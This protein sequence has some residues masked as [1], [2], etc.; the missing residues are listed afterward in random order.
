MTKPPTT[1]S[2]SIFDGTRHKISL[3]TALA[4][5]ISL[6]IADPIAAG[7]HY[8]DEPVFG[9]SFYYEAYGEQHGISVVLCHGTGDLGGRIW[10]NSVADLSERFHVYVPD[11]PGFGR[12]EKRNELYSPENYANFLNWFIKNYTQPPVYLVGHSMGGAISLYFAGIYPKTIEKLVLVDAAGI[13]HRA[14]F[15]KNVLDELITGEFKVGSM[16][17]LKE[18]LRSLKHMVNSTIESID[19]NLMPD[20][21]S[22]ALR[23]PVFRK[24]VLRGDP[25]RISGMAL[26]Q[27]D[28]SG[29]MER[30]TVPTH[31]IWG[32]LDP[33]APLRTGIMLAVDISKTYLIV[34]K[35]LGHSPMLE[36]PERFNSSL[37]KALASDTVKSFA[38]A[39]NRPFS[40]AERSDRTVL[41]GRGTH[42]EGDFNILLI[43]DSLNITLENLTAKKIIIENSEVKLDNCVIRSKTEG[44]SVINSTATL[45]GVFVSGSTAILSD[46]SKLDIAGSYLQGREESVLARTATTVLF[47]VSRVKSLFQNSYKHGVVKL[48][49]GEQI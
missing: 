44:I 40:S 24:T 46:N 45:T 15:T 12:S 41:G 10:E 49:P 27:T 39:G 6:F 22:E 26:I 8:A 32:E 48:G 16:N 36:D 11:L 20:D 3:L 17:V 19:S 13:L 31:L 33:I 38:K 30:V 1:L 21:M 14:A 35:N 34:L 9:G 28:F 18:P 5:M 42:L 29:I 43:K 4:L 25:L 23:M 2:Y 37:L 7:G 47:S